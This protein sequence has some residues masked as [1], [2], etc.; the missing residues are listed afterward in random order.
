MSSSDFEAQ[1]LEYLKR[2]DRHLFV[3]AEE[4]LGGLRQRVETQYLTTD[5]R[6]RMW[7]LIDGDRNI[8]DIAKETEVSREAVRLFLTELASGPQPIVEWINSSRGRIPERLV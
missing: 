7:D 2:I 5:T 8:A 3:L 1:V 6:R 4:K